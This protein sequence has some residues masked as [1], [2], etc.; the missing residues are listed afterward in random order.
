ML[1]NLSFS[2]GT[3]HCSQQWF[4]LLRDTIR[5]LRLYMRPLDTHALHIYHSALA[6]TRS[7]ELQQVYTANRQ[8]RGVRLVFPRI[9]TGDVS[10]LRHQLDMRS[11]VDNNSLFTKGII[12]HQASISCA[13][14]SRDGTLLATGCAYERSV[15]IW[16]TC[17]GSMIQRVIFPEQYIT[18]TIACVFSED[19]NIVQVR[20]HQA[21]IGW[22]IRPRESA[23]LVLS[24]DALDSVDSD[25]LKWH[26]SSTSVHDC[27]LK[28]LTPY[29]DHALWIKGAV[30]KGDFS[31]DL[32]NWLVYTPRWHCYPDRK[33]W[34]DDGRDTFIIGTLPSHEL[35]EPIPLCWL[36][37][38]LISF[39]FVSEYS[40]S[41]NSATLA[42]TT[43]I[44]KV[45]ILDLSNLVVCVPV[46]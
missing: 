26:H 20:D 16:N 2:D 34:N 6:I 23:Y 19:G 3:T 27:G 35:Y 25:R 10:P 12:V 45:V 43:M 36:Q 15:I 4:G 46:G 14:F 21:V 24:S 22:I 41:P 38:Y 30:M 5:V 13:S 31:I 1:Q 29:D 40:W 9:D 18:L 17:T 39:A 11:C 32:A 28:L 7:C 37:D 8:Q 33:Y 42:I 44:G